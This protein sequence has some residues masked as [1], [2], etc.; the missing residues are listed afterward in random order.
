MLALP[1]LIPSI[2][3]G[4]GGER[5]RGKGRGRD[6]IRRR[7]GGGGKI[8]ETMVLNCVFYTFY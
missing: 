5:E 6:D 7:R 2:N 8:K 3:K 1:S 4:E